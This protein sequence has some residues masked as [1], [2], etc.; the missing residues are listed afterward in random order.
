[1][2]GYSLAGFC[3]CMQEKE[4]KIKKKKGQSRLRMERQEWVGLNL[5][6]QQML[7]QPYESFLTSV[8]W[9]IYL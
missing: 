7:V 2:R 6:R 5:D 3:Q 1:M 4:P 8:L 9:F